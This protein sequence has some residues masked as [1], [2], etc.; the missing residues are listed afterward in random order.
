MKPPAFAQIVPTSF[1]EP[2]LA[3]PGWRAAK[4]QLLTTETK[5]APH[6]L[7]NHSNA[8]CAEDIQKITNRRRKKTEQHTWLVAPKYGVVRRKDR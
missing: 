6:P 7:S 8:K 4:K 1:S 5:L 2:P 3:V